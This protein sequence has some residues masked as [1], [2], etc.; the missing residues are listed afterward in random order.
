[1]LRFYFLLIIYC[2]LVT[3]SLL[4]ANEIFQLIILLSGSTII[5]LAVIIW[6]VSNIRSQMF[7]RS[8]NSN[9]KIKDKVAITYDDGPHE[10]NTPK[11]L[12]ILKKN[13][14]KASFFI[15][16]EN[17]VKYK[18][19]AEN[20]FFDGHLIGNH[21]YY[22]S[23][24]FPIKLPNKIK[25]ELVKTQN[26][27]KKLTQH[28]N[29]YFRPPY[30]V[31][32][33]F[34]AMALSKLKLKVIGWNIR[35]FDTSDK[36]KELILKRITKKLKGGDIILLHDRTKHICWL[37]EEILKYLKENKLKAVTIEELLF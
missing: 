11:L 23:N 33:P 35:S 24:T 20:I 25:Q 18:K 12:E 28:E 17:I 1:M 10:E 31:T 19:I 8:S 15:I 9:P 3:C 34:V 2:L 36:N 6:G 27:I 4:F 22:H 26:E 16:G 29:Y 30:G 14:A 5:Y 37:T 32:N 21:S 13:N 7:V